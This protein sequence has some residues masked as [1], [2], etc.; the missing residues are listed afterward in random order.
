LSDFFDMGGYGAYVWAAFGFALVVLV[1]LLVQSWTAARGRD[2]EFAQLKA[3]AR[4]ETTGRTG[5]RRAARPPTI[6]P[7]RVEE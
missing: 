4:P 3:M 1:G 6:E 7:A 2:R 5:V